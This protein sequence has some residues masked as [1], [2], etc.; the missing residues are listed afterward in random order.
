MDARGGPFA[1]GASMFIGGELGYRVLRR[2]APPASWLTK[3]SGATK[4]TPSKL[5]AYW[6]PQV[7]DE[8]IDRTVIDFGCRTGA[9]AVEVARHG[10]RHVTGIDIVPEALAVAARAAAA[11]NV[12]HRCTFTT[13]AAGKADR[14][15]CIDAFEHFEDPAGILGVMAGLLNPG[16]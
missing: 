4:P 6:G 13:E 9:D 11:A 12:A 8:L 5:Q 14:I 2:F 15:I 10:A 1:Q 7:W 16:G 3:L